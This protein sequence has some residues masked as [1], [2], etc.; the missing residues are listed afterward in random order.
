MIE[1]KL[2]RI[3]FGFD[4]V[5]DPYVGYL[6]TWKK[7]LPEYEIIHWNADNL[8][9]DNCYFSETMHKYKDHAFLSDYYR[10][11][12]LKNYG[13][14]YLDADIE[15]LDGKKF[16]QIVIELD[17]SKEFDT[18]IGIDHKD[19]GWYTAH[20]MA[21]TADSRM[22]TFMCEA[23]EKLGPISLWRRKIFYMMAPQFASLYF[24]CNGHN[25]DGMG[26]SP[27]LLSPQIV[28]SVK[29][30]PQ[31]YFAP[32]APLIDVNTGAGGYQINAFTENSC[33]CHHFACSWHGT[34]SPYFKAAQKARNSNILFHQ[35]LALEGKSTTVKRPAK[36]VRLIRTLP[37]LIQK[38]RAYLRSI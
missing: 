27:F 37:S 14:V 2:H 20:S 19:G 12:I 38:L 1:K 9:M 31:E 7:E 3:F 18:V 13:G 33:L 36:I 30:Y 34:D 24:A 15:I 35:L 16:N 17:D 10:W 26:T 32:M 5:E 25:V 22:P 11:W 21:A 6:E 8:P 28:A 29:I 23:Y 4:S